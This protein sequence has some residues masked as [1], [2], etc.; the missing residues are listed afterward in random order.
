[1]ILQP[2]QDPRRMAGWARR[3]GLTELHLSVEHV[4]RDPAVVADPA[5]GGARTHATAGSSA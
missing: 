4:R 5:R 3:C 2:W 1:M